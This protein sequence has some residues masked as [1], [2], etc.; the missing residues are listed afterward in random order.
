MAGNLSNQYCKLRAF[1]I[2]DV[3]ES[4]VNWLNNKEINQFLESRF[5]H[6]TVKSVTEQVSLWIDNESYMFYT[7]LC[8]ITNEHVG[9][10][11]LGPINKYHQT[12]DIGYFIGNRAFTGKGMATNALIL[13]SDYAFQRG[14]KKITAGAYAINFASIRVMEKAGFSLECIRKSHVIFNGNRINSVLYAKYAT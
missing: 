8:P 14:V 11:K 4:L 6:H 7:I 9:N 2:E 13:L 5:E 1:S 3:T 10:I 12:A